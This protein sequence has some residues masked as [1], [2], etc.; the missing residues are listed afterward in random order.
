[1]GSADHRGCDSHRPECACFAHPA[2]G[3]L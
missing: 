3:D 1:L 2:E